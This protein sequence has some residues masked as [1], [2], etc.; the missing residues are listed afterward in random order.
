MEERLETRKKTY[1]KR[2]FI[3]EKEVKGER[4][5]NH[6]VSAVDS[7]GSKGF[8]YIFALSLSLATCDW[9]SVVLCVPAVLCKPCGLHR[10][11][12]HR[13]TA[14]GAEGA[15]L[16]TGRSNWTGDS[17]PQIR[18]L[19]RIQPGW[20]TTTGIQA[21]PERG[22]ALKNQVSEECT[23]RLSEALVGGGAGGGGEA[24]IKGGSIERKERK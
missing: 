15:A 13:G 22:C 21:S 4:F 9:A 10:Q 24:K 23:G 11:T 17:G 6:W 7:S 8:F 3:R 2:C 5:M 19:R 20:E 14:C 18:A 12:A 16:F 1:F